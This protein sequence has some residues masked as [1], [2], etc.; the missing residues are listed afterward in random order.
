MKNWDKSGYYTYFQFEMGKSPSLIVVIEII[1]HL[2]GVVD[3][4]LH[5][6]EKTD[7]I[8]N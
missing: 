6:G 1:C 5:G 2:N 4:E 8:L 3:Q 7:A